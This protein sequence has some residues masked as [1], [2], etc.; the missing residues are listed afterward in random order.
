MVQP[1]ISAGALF[2]CLS[3]NRYFFLLRSSTSSYPS[4]WSL[5]GG[6]IFKDE[7]IMDGL[8]RELIEELGYL[9]TISNWINFN[10][11]RSID[12]KFEY[13]SILIT[14]PHEFIP[15]LNGENDG[16]AWVDLDNPPKPLHPR[17]RE[18]LTSNILI[19]CIKK[20]Q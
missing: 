11:F 19:D 9:P 6:K 17:L 5:C 7:Q 18:V 14:T 20:F 1:I 3:T 13:H 2:K 4:R 12:K 8:K 10:W 15:N 16:Y